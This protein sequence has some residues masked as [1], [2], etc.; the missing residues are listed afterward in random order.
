MK[1]PGEVTIIVLPQPPPRNAFPNQVPQEPSQGFLNTVGNYVESRRLVTTNIHVIGPKFVS[2]NVACSVFLKKRVSASEAFKS[3]QDALADFFDPVFG[4]P[5][6]GM[7]WPFGRP[8]FPSEVS[9]LL[10]QLPGV[11]YVT[12]VQFNDQKRGEPLKLAYNGLP[13]PGSHA[14][15]MVPFESRGGSPAQAGCKGNECD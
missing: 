13:R 2:V 12:S 4:G 6:K 9:Q 15:T 7:G 1:M 14:I 5:D 8:V 10:A 11:D 3:V